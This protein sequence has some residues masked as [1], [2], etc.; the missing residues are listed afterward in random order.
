MAREDGSTPPPGATASSN[1]SSPVYET[2]TGNGD[3]EKKQPQQQQQRRPTVSEA[4]DTIKPEDFMSVHKIPCARDGYM[5]GMLTG[6]VAGAGRYILGAQI[7][8]AMNWAAGGFILGAI[9]KWEHCQYQRRKEK[10]GVARMF[11]I[12]AQKAA[13]KKRKVEEEAR[14]K[15][16]AEEKARQAR[17]WYKFW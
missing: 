6:V 13:D 9:V 11:E 1:K 4:W 5:T 14:L 15:A 16:E 8:K 10:E 12:M 3:A 17:R 2:F 7:P